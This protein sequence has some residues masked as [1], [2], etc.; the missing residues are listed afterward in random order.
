MATITSFY[1]AW[2]MLPMFVSRQ[3]DFNMCIVS[4]TTKINSFPKHTYQ[5]SYLP[6]QGK[7]IKDR[8]LW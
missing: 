5:T 1:Y 3:Q 7:A 2:S 4:W 8:H 6:K